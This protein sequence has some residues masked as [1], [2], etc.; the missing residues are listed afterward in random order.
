MSLHKDRQYRRIARI[1]FA[2]RESGSSDLKQFASALIKVPFLFLFS[3]F[4]FFL[5]FISF[6]FLFYFF[7]H[8][9]FFYSSFYL[10][11]RSSLPSI[12][13]GRLLVFYQIT[14]RNVN[15]LKESFDQCRSQTLAA[16]TFLLL[17]LFVHS[18]LMLYLIYQNNVNLM[19]DIFSKERK[20]NIS[21]VSSIL[22]NRINFNKKFT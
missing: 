15:N 18:S 17:L 16:F 19:Y 14:I 7:L 9:S 2:F 12:D 21:F 6:L 5:F 20:K 22:T 8:S 10:F 4:L 13:H 3:Y 1:S 11:I